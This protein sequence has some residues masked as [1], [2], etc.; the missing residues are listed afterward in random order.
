MA[1]RW[2]PTPR[3]AKSEKSSKKKLTST[4]KLQRE[5]KFVCLPIV[6]YTA[7]ITWMTGDLTA[8]CIVVSAVVAAYTTVQALVIKK[9]ERENLHKYPEGV[10]YDD[11]K[12]I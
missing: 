3:K 8:W 11:G 1:L 4:Q 12:V 7:V 2:V 10:P 9:N 5:T 6:L